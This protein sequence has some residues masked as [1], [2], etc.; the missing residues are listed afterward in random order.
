VSDLTLS[1]H[2][3]LHQDILKSWTFSARVLNVVD[4]HV[5]VLLHQFFNSRRA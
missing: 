3:S 1:F 2:T 5:W 4:F